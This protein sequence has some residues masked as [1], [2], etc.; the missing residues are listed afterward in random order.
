M[1]YGCALVGDFIECADIRGCSKEWIMQLIDQLEQRRLLA[2]T[3]VKGLLTIEGSAG[4]DVISLSVDKKMRAIVD[5]QPEGF[6]Q[7]FRFSTAQ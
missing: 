4:D 6:H 3:V 5:I 7:C 1:P 2:A